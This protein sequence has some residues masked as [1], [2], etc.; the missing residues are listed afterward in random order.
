LIGAPADAEVAASSRARI[1]TEVAKEFF[2][3]EHGRD[4]LDAREVVGQITKDSRPRSQTV[5]G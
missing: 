3:A 5:A 1:R 2:H 4:P